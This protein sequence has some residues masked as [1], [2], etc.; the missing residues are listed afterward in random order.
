MMALT[1]TP[2]TPA[3]CGGG[4]GGGCGCYSYSYCGCGC[5]YGGGYG[6]GYGGGCCGYGTTGGKGQT[7]EGK[8][9]TPSGY[10]DDDDASLRKGRAIIKVKLPADAKL[11][12]DSSATKQ[13]S[14]VRKFRTP[15]L[16]AGKK[17]TYTLTAEVVRDGQKI[18]T[19]KEVAVR[20]GQNTEISLS[21][22]TV[23]VRK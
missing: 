6:Y 10:D 11:F 12:V 23:T 13:T 22:P 16:K 14:S 7:P 20:R 17:F 4:G 18:T 21:F 5:G 8:G 9:Q 15:A 19:T 1:T 2:A 3:C